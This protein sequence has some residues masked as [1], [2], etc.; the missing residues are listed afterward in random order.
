MDTKKITAFLGELVSY[1]D[2]LKLYHWHVSGE[3]SYAEHIAID[4]AIDEINDPID[5]LVET[6]YAIAG[7]LDIQIPVTKRPTNLV[8]YVEDFYAR[9]ESARELFGDDFRDGIIDEIQQGN[10]QLLYRVK[11]L[12]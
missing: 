1:R 11:R 3:G 6:T 12:K 8:K 10:Q 2:G 9:I 4:Q 5:A 7:D